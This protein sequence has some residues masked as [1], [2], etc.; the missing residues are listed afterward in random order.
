MNKA[1]MI[2]EIVEKLKLVNI[3]VIKPESIDDNKMDELTEIYEMVKKR[4]T[5]SPSEMSAL[6][7]ALGS[8]RK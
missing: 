6:T 3:G 1:E 4:D 5:F 7:D 8:L 2:D